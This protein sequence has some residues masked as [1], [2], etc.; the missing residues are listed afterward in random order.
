MS[1]D[2][3]N[4]VSHF[5]SRD[6][7]GSKRELHQMIKSATAN[8]KLDDSKLLSM[9]LEHGAPRDSEAGK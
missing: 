9:L 1:K 5:L 6:Q 2:S 4:I 8:G 3:L 7:D